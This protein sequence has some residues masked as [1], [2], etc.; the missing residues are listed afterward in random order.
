VTAPR[1]TPN[2]ATSTRPERSSTR[3]A[4]KK[5]LA[6]L[7]WALLLALLALLALVFLAINAIDDDGPDGPAGDS[8]GQVSGSNGSG[9]NG[10]DG[11][12]AGA[13]PSA[14][15]SAVPSAAASALP[16]AAA[17]ALPSAGAGTG[18]AASGAQLKVADQ[19]LLALTGGS[20]AGQVGKPVT[21]STKVQSVVSDE[22]FWAGSS[23]T[24]R[25]FV[26]L[27]PEARKAN[28]ESKFQV[29]AGQTV[30]LTGTMETPQSAPKAIAGVTAAEG[31]DQLT[32]QGALVSAKT[33]ELAG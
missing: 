22:G 27:T 2:P 9:I 8:L 1:T 33:I 13:L 28:G 7:P 19:D 6:W 20:L 30:Q 29:K 26:Y 16:S 15:A 5:P 17:S 4:H 10:Q 23:T 32:S 18:G 14:A 31:L 24:E 3:V 11:D 21:G 25:T 12:G